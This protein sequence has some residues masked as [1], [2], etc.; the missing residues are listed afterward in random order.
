MAT[1]KLALVR[2]DAR[3]SLPVVSLVIVVVNIVVA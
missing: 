1:V 2:G 3:T